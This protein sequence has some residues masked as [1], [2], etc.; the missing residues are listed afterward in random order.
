MNEN[1]LSLTKEL[2][3]T[4]PDFKAQ[5]IPIECNGWRGEHEEL[6][7]KC[8]DANPRGGPRLIYMGVLRFPRLL[9][10]MLTSTRQHHNLGVGLVGRCSFASVGCVQT[11]SLDTLSVCL[12]PHAARTSG[13]C[14]RCSRIHPHT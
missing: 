14:P 9:L 8:G 11:P 4:I 6:M 5:V 3:L 1:L 7:K 2:L 10:T 13:T 12:G